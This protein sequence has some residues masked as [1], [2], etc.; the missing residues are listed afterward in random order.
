M[1]LSLFEV[2]VKARLGVSREQGKCSPSTRTITN[3]PTCLLA[4]SPEMILFA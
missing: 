4:L 1:P 2:Q 3:D